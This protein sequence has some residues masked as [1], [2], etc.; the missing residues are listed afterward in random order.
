MSYKVGTWIETY[1]GKRFDF[2]NPMPSMVD[3]PSIAHALAAAPRFGGHTPMRY[4]VAQH[5]VE[6][7]HV[8]PI[9]YELEALLHDAHEAYVCDVPLPMKQLLSGYNTVERAA[10]IAV[11]KRFAVPLTM[12]G[13]VKEIDRRMLV[14]EARAFGMGW[15]REWQE[16]G[17]FPY[18]SLVLVPLSPADAEKRFLSRF[19]DLIR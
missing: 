5:C 18:E 15:W 1:S 10:E 13:V 2:S 9:G 19:E 4:S 6:C 14:T 8:A 7:S 12:S 11:R 3:L 17:I 16:R